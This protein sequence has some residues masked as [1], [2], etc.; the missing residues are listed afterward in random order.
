MIVSLFILFAAMVK[1]EYTT[2]EPLTH[3]QKDLR[4][5]LGMSEIL[6]HPLPITATTNEIYK[7]A[8]RLGYSEHDSSAIYIRSKF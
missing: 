2:H 6:E 3:V 5:A 1:G 8:K 4:I 7:H